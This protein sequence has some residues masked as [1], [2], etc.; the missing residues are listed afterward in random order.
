MK[1]GNISQTIVPVP[2]FYTDKNTRTVELFKST[3]TF[4]NKTLF[5]RSNSYFRSKDILTTNCDLNINHNPR[6]F[7]HEREDNEKLKYIPLYDRGKFPNNADNKKTYFPNIIDTFKVKKVDGPSNKNEFNNVKKFLKNTDLNTFLKKDLR[8]EIIENT[9]NLLD[10]INVAYDMNRW[11]EF[12]CRVTMNNVFQT[13]Y[14]PIIDMIQNTTDYK[15]DF[16]KTLDEKSLSLKTISDKTRMSLENNIKKKERNNM[17]R[18]MNG[19]MRNKSDLDSLLNKNRTNLLNLKNNN[20]EPPEYSKEDQKFI[21]ENKNITKK[22]NTCNLYNNFPSKTRMEFE[23]KKVYPN[24]KLFSVNDDWGAINIDK[25][26]CKKEIF[27]CLD[28]MW[29]RPLHIDAF[30]IRK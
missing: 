5:K 13:A 12:D 7:N 1:L 19:L 4:G 21:N 6:T 10:R 2:K 24:K 11:N 28:K 9:K 14:S 30:K 18:T 27:C 26:K 17:S 23:V 22:I 3:K 20:Q 29:T 8:K 15:E 25:Y 16:M